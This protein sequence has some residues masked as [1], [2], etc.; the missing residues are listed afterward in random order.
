VDGVGEQ[1]NAAADGDDDH[2]EGSRDH[3]RYERYLQRPDP[4]VCRQAGIE[5]C[6]LVPVGV[7]LEEMLKPVDYFMTRMPVVMPV[8][9]FLVFRVFVF[10]MLSHSVPLEIRVEVMVFSQNP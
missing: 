2:L 1:G 6:F 4:L 3:Q 8:V 10:I 9:M 5:G 7:R